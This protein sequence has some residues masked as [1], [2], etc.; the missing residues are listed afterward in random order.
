MIRIVCC[1]LVLVACR[2]V[3]AS[4]GDCCDRCGCESACRKVCR[5]VRETKKV[6]KVT[7][8]CQCEDFCVPGPSDH[9]VVCDECGNKKHVYTQTCAHMRTRKKLVKHET[10]EEVPSHK[11]IV[12]TVCDACAAKFGDGATPQAGGA[13]GVQTFPATPTSYIENAGLTAQLRRMLQ[14]AFGQK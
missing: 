7:Y 9:S 4:A 14:P 8:S 6:P 2:T 1:A 5:A 10:V 11:W 13:L 3:A 12:E